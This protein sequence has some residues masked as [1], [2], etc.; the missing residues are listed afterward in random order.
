[1]PGVSRG[2]RLMTVEEQAI[3]K[4]ARLDPTWYTPIPLPEEVQKFDTPVTHL[5]VGVT[6]KVGLLELE[7]TRVEGIT[8]V[9]RHYQQGPLYIFRPLYIDPQQLEMAFI[10]TIQLGDGLLQ[11][12]RYRMD[13]TCEA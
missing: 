12:D 8:R 7:L 10:Y 5:G 13:I 11:G 9:T 6:D 4:V 3:R 2:R 1:M